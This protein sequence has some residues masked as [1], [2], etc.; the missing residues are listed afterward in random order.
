MGAHRNPNI[1]IIICDQLRRDALGCMGNA[2][3]RTPHLDRLAA[4][5]VIFERA[6]TTTPVC[7]P[8]RDSLLTGRYAYTLGGRLSPGQAPTLAEILSER[9]YHCAALGKMHWVPPRGDFGFHVV[10]LSEDTGPGRFLDDYQ[11]FL[12][13]RGLEEWSHGLD[14]Y[15]L[16]WATS[17]LPR[18]CHVTTW[19]GDQVVHYLERE[20][21]DGRPFFA[22]AS[23]VKPHPP[24][25][26]PPPFDRIYSPADMPPPVRPEPLEHR[27]RHIQDWAETSAF[28]RLGRPD[29]AARIKAHYYG[30]VQQI[31]EQVGRIVGVL[32]ERGLLEETAIFFLADHGEML[33]DQ[34][35]YSKHYPYSASIGIPLLA[36]LPGVRPGTCRRFVNLTDV[37]A[38]CCRL[39]GARPPDGTVGRDLREVVSGGDAVDDF[40]VSVGGDGTG[41]GSW[42]ALVSEE[43]KYHYYVNG[44]EAELFALGHQGG[45]GGLDYLQEGRNL[46]AEAAYRDV[47]RELHARLT[48]WLAACDRRCLP[49]ARPYL[50]DGR[51]PALPFAPA[52]GWVAD[53]YQV[54]RLPRFVPQ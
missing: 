3:V 43:W 19:N 37:F 9:G 45:R 4:Q 6:F 14:N 12:A 8:A 32:E 1:L 46:A 2:V 11:R 28:N 18:E 10:R 25:D 23:F 15:D 42:V 31:D 5:S 17:R 44:G 35:L 39:A 52:H 47:C 24:F 36:R 30:L 38:T 34:Y 7:G 29:W 21:P 22:V 48:D 53:R 51:I 40:H 16:M 26:P 27:S 13:E 33:G 50:Q 49:G 41:R 54:H 20:R